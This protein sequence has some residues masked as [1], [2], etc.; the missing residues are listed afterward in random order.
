MSSAHLNQDVFT[1]SN[2]RGKRFLLIL[3][4]AAIVLFII[5]SIHFFSVEG[6]GFLLY[7]LIIAVILIIGTIITI[8]RFFGIKYI[9]GTDAL[10]I[11]H[12]LLTKIIPYNTITNVEFSKPTNFQKMGGRTSSIPYI[13]SPVLGLLVYGKSPQVSMYGVNLQK[14]ILISRIAGK[15]IGITPENGDIFIKQINEKNTSIGNPD[16]DKN[17]PLEQSQEIISS[18]RRNESILFVS[19]LVLAA[20]SLIYAL[21]IY[22]QLNEQIPVHFNITGTPDRNGD[23]S[24]FLILQIFYSSLG[25]L[26]SL[27]V[28]FILI[29]NKPLGKTLRGV[30]IMIIPVLFSIGL[31]I[32]NI[33]N[34]RFTLANS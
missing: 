14:L 26:F 3:V 4:L 24:E 27:I 20:I 25:I 23:K 17:K 15:P 11:K 33:V 18:Y 7:F 21:Y 19:A 29:R 5:V 9:L 6:K 2:Y 12:G 13:Y 34:I 30:Q 28:Y 31:L 16:F 8:D 32:I 1:G 10:I 22:P